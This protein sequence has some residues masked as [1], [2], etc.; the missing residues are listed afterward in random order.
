MPVSEALV[1]TEWLAGHLGSPDVRVVDAT[2]YLPNQGRD[3]K[4]EH[5]AAHIPGAVYFDIDDI[6]DDGSSLPHMLPSPAKFSSRV[7]KLGLGDGVRIVVYDANRFMASAR[8]WWMFRLFG[9]GDV[10]VLDGGLGKWRAED[11]PVDDRP[12]RPVERHFTAR[13]NNMLVRDLDQ[14]RANLAR[15][16]EQVVDVRS[17]G[18]FNATDPE[19]R[20]GLRAG[21]IPGSVNLPFSDLVA[22][23]ATLNPRDV[24]QERVAQAGIDLERPIVTSCGSGVSAAVLSLALFTLGHPGAAVYDGSWSEWGSRTDT[25]IDR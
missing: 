22:A 16:M 18:R 9:H 24:L 2:W 4:A 21:H 13:L 23:D 20:P 14:M 1:S 6:A 17:A 3:A 8:V 12:V 25:P 10:T 7:R 11:R 5:A 19:P 15:R